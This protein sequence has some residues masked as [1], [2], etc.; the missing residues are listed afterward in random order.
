[1]IGFIFFI[2]FIF[3]QILTVREREKGLNHGCSFKNIKTYQLT[4]FCYEKI[5]ANC[6]FVFELKLNFFYKVEK[7]FI[8]FNLFDHII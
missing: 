7:K 6:V 5:K 2:F 1:M 8:E 3:W 4:Y